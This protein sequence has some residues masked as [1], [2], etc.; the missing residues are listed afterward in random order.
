MNVTQPC[1]APIGPASTN[2]DTL[3]TTS[4]NSSDDGKESSSSNTTVSPVSKPSNG[5]QFSQDTN[6][7]IL[8]VFP[9]TTTSDTVILV[10]VFENAS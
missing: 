8:D 2:S 1:E 7:F 4:C 3:S 10:V 5:K 6:H 9:K